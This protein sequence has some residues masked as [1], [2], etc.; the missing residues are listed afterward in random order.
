MEWVSD[1]SVGR[2]SDWVFGMRTLIDGVTT[3]GQRLSFRYTEL[4]VGESLCTD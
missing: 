4:S 3:E 2:L 1:R